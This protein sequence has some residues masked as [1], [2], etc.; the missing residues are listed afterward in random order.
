MEAAQRELAEEVG[1]I[2]QRLTSLGKVRP[3]PAILTNWCHL[4]LAEE[5]VCREKEQDD[6]EDIF[7]LPVP[8][9]NIPRLIKAGIINHSLTI[10][11]FYHLWAR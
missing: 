11:C 3:N 4:F 8:L 2:G 10:N 7:V 9:E 6:G 1:H 5:L